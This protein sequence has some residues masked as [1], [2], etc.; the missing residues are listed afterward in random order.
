MKK[1]LAYVY[2]GC[3][4]VPEERAGGLLKIRVGWGNVEQSI[5]PVILGRSSNLWE[6]VCLGGTDQSTNGLTN[7][8]PGGRLTCLG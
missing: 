1:A 2:D 5:E 4:A 7:E 3:R 6:D 8:T